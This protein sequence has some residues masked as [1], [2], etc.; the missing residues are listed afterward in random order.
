MKMLL[1]SMYYFKLQLTVMLGFYHTSHP[2]D[3]HWRWNHWKYK[4]EKQDDRRLS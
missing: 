3:I 1:F 4:Y 2:L